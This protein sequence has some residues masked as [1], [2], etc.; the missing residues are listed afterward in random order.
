MEHP[1]N[2]ACPQKESFVNI[3]EHEA[4]NCVEPKRKTNGHI[5]WKKDTKIL[6]ISFTSALV[7]VI[8]ICAIT[9]R[10]RRELGEREE[11]EYEEIQP[12]RKEAKGDETPTLNDLR[13]FMCL[14]LSSSLHVSGAY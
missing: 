10:R 5:E 13:Y 14:F 7:F 2:K 1:L 4:C 12:S 3:I 8:V 11:N 6:W 9:K